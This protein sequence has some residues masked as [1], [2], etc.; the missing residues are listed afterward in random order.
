MNILCICVCI[1]VTSKTDFITALMYDATFAWAHAAKK[2]LEQG[3]YPSS[4]EM[5]LF[6]RNV[7]HHLN[8]LDFEGKLLL[9]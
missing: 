4:D 2:T 3:I 5:R 1:H 6:G 7:S 9:A 8:N